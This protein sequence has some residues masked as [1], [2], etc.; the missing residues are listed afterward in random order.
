MNDLFSYSLWFHEKS[1]L[2]TYVLWWWGSDYG[3]KWKKLFKDLE[4]SLD[5]MHVEFK[6]SLLKELATDNSKPHLS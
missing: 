2:L 1:A 5:I 4:M 3:T 6:V